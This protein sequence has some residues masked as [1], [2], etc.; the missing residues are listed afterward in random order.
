MQTMAVSTF[1]PAAT[2]SDILRPAR[3]R[4]DWGYPLFVA[5]LSHLPDHPARCPLTADHCPLPADH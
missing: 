2:S 1:R 3:R 4:A 5:T